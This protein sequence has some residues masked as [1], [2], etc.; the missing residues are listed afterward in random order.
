MPF[1]FNLYTNIC[2]FLKYTFEGDTLSRSIKTALVV[3]S[4]LGAIN[5]GQDILSGQL[6]WHWIIPLLVT[7]LVPFSVT[8]FGQVQGKRQRDR[9]HSMEM[10]PS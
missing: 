3:G 10:K 2:I 5:H 4:I 9:L 6:S 1:I 8:T 7:Y